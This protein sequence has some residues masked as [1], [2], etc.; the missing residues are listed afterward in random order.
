MP[1]MPMPPIPTKWIGPIWF[2]SFMVFQTPGTPD[3]RSIGPNNGRPHKMI[4]LIWETGVF[5][6]SQ[7]RAV[8]GH[9]RLRD[10]LRPPHM[11]PKAIKT[12]AVKPA[13]RCGGV[14][15]RGEAEHLR[16]LARE[17]LRRDNPNAGIDEGRDVA[18]LAGLK[19]SI[20]AHGEIAGPVDADRPGAGRDQQQDVHGPGIETPGEARDVRARPL[21]PEGVG[22]ADQER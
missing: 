13:V 22:V 14:K 19:P 17:Q 4:P 21:D 15:E 7:G 18:R 8:N 2:G 3:P 11:H 1:D 12:N 9:F 10:A 5:S 20:V 16:R 6:R